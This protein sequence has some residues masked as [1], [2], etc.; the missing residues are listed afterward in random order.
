MKGRVAGVVALAGLLVS[1]ACAPGNV[2]FQ[3]GRKA[4]LRKDWDTALINYDKAAQSRPEN[5]E[6]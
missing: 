2:Y 5:A 4:E 1:T 6:Y 3:K